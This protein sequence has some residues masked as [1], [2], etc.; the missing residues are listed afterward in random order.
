MEEENKIIKEDIFW[1]S[2]SGSAS[3]VPGLY[4]VI[5]DPSSDSSAEEYGVD[6]SFTSFR[7]EDFVFEGYP[8]PITGSWSKVLGRCPVSCVA[9][10]LNNT[11]CDLQPCL[12]SMYR[13]LNDSSISFELLRGEASFS[14]LPVESRGQQLGDLNY[15][16]LSSGWAKEQVAAKI[17]FIRLYRPNVHLDLNSVCCALV[18]EQN[19]Y[20]C[21][22]LSYLDL[23]HLRSQ[24]GETVGIMNAETSRIASEIL[25]AKQPTGHDY[26]QW[27]SALFRAADYFR[28]KNYLGLLF[29]DDESV[30]VMNY[31]EQGIT[32]KDL[33]T[34]F[35]WYRTFKHD[36]HTKKGYCCI[37]CNGN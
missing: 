21:Q 31:R 27:G 14:E 32:G 35:L 3:S 1:S 20:Y 15:E 10:G 16:D 34:L 2:G 26:Q 4:E 19:L 30:I 5:S 37:L 25:W 7:V 33:Y 11:A 28:Y 18:Q 17:D 8:G 29:P 13:G 36:A 6:S 12:N 23:L 9:G 24:T 22:F